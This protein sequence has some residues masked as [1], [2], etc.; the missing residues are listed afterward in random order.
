MKEWLAK[1]KEWWASLAMREKQMVSIG[2]SLLVLFIIYQWMWTP[3]LEHVA[4]MRTKIA[5]DQKT[6]LWMQAADTVMQKIEGKSV[7]KN[8]PV[9][10]V[11]FLSQVQ[12]QIKHD[13]LEQL[14]TQLKQSTNESIDIHFQKVE[15]EK[16]MKLIVA[17]MKTHPITITHLTLVA[18]GTPGY[19]NADIVMKQG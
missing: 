7:A 9:S 16:L 11:V 13:G 10:L 19:V 2:G 4:T 8:K 12:K 18:V 5:A 14:L 1:L 3:Y 17:I 6:L 15:F